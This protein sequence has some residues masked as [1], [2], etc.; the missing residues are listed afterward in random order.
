MSVLFLIVHPGTDT[1]IDLN[2]AIVVQVDADIYAE[3]E[4]MTTDELLEIATRHEKAMEMRP[5]VAW[6]DFSKKG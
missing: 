3:K 6:V 1:M 2:E 4:P 5:P